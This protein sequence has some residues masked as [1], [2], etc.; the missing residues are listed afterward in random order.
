M[1]QVLYPPPPVPRR[2][3][4]EARKETNLSEWY[5]QVIIKAEMVEYYDVSGCYIL[6]PWAYGIWERIQG[7]GDGGRGGGGE[8]GTGG[9][10]RRVVGM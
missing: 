10:G 9:G 4:M 3:G 5:S 8:G 1:T 2:L 7:G 6:R